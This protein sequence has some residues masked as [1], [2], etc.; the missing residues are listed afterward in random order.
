MKINTFIIFA[1]FCGLLISCTKW[2][3]RE[4]SH[5]IR[6]AQLLKE[7]TPDSALTLLDAVNTSGFS[8]AERAEYNLLQIQAK[9]NAGMDVSAETGISDAREYFIRKK[10]PQKAALVCFY[11]AI[12]AE[13]KQTTAAM[14]YYQEALE[15]SKNTDNK[16][17]QGKILWAPLKT[18]KFSHTYLDLVINHYI[19]LQIQNSYPN[20]IFQKTS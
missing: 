9:R 12:V 13:Q 3:S 15:F 8:K 4:N 7:Q 18:P 17:L 5:L 10:D 11:A 6:Q 2:G 16:E 14:E 20:E 1:L 19:C